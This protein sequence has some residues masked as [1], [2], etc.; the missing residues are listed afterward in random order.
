MVDF[1]KELE[2]AT[3]H[4]D[5]IAK[6]WEP[7]KKPPK[8]QKTTPVEGLDL[9]KY[10]SIDKVAQITKLPIDKYSP[11]KDDECSKKLFRGAWHF[12]ESKIQAGSDRSHAGKR[13]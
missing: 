11:Y 8:E 9:R 10:I 13:H 12:P 2:K 5:K 7:K 1:F 3:K 4:L 6:E